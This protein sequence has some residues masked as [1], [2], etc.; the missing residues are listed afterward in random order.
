LHLVGYIKHSWP[1]SARRWR[2][3]LA[4]SSD[5]QDDGLHASE[6]AKYRWYTA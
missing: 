1:Q 4:A 6:K 3:L 5:R 2:Q